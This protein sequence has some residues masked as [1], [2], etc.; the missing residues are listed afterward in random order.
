MDFVL[1]LPRTRKGRDIVF[2]VVDR[3]SKM[4][5]FIPC[6]KTDDATHFADLFFEKLFVCMVRQKQLFL[7]VMPNF[8]ATFEE[9]YGQNL[10]LRF[11][12]LPFIIPKLMV[13]LKLLTEPC[14]PC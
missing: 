4:A 9:F 6:H 14:L 5:H 13:K 7:I 10:K 8:L 1:G 3:F 11:Y 12:F 2:V